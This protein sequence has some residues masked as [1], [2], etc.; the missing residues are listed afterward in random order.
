MQNEKKSRILRVT[1]ICANCGIPFEAHNTTTRFCSKKCYFR[2]YYLHHP[3]CRTRER[4]ERSPKTSKLR[5]PARTNPP[6]DMGGIDTERDLL[7]IKEAA[8]R[9]G[10]CKQTMYNLIHSNQIKAIRYTSRLSFVRWSEILNHSN[11]TS[12]V[13]PKID[14][15]KVPQRMRSEK[16]TKAAKSNLKESAPLW[17]TA[18]Q[19]RERYG[20]TSNN[21]VYGYASRYNIAKKRVYRNTLYSSKSF[22]AVLKPHLDK[23]IPADQITMKEVSQ[24]YKIPISTIRYRLDIWNI[25]YFRAHKKIYFSETEFVKKSKGLKSA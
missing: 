1:R 23:T 7:S 16:I 15:P 25:K 19:V 6:P 22:D 9:L 13:I 24:K 10:V 11:R 2:D 12:S 21:C 5:N 17:L 3:K 20:F 18:Q 4:A 8:K 14:P